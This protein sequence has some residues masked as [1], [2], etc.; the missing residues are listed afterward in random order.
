MCQLFL[1]CLVEVND[2]K[3]ETKQSK[4][5]NAELHQI[6]SLRKIR[7]TKTAKIAMTALAQK[8]L[9]VYLMS[10]GPINSSS[11]PCAMKASYSS[12]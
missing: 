4:N 1:G 6:D 12:L 11:F 3:V 8:S 9:K 5:K 7:L 2:V 10:H